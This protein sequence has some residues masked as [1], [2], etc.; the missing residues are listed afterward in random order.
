MSFKSFFSE[1]V[2]RSDRRFMNGLFQ[3]RGSMMQELNERYDKCAVWINRIE[4]AGKSLPALFDV[5]KSMWK[6]GVQH[7]N[8][9]P[10][11][12]GM[13]R[14]KDIA[15]MTMDEVYLGNVDGLWT[16]TLSE[17]ERDKEKDMREMGEKG[18]TSIL[19]SYYLR[20][21]RQYRELL[22]SNVRYLQ[23]QIFEGKQDIKNNLNRHQVKEC[24]DS[25]RDKEKKGMRFGM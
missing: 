12:F 1:D 5:H 6:D 24:I 9:G 20:V 22:L 14:T 17:W 18:Y 8:F 10:D 3:S 16:F 11:K 13:F 21:C 25:V 7:S 15:T 23:S 4:Q 2:N 19:P